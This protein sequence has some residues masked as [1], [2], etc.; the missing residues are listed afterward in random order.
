[1]SQLAIAVQSGAMRTEMRVFI[2]ESLGFGAAGV[3][4]CHEPD[5]LL[6]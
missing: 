2:A 5:S 6:P 3:F 4:F 1:M